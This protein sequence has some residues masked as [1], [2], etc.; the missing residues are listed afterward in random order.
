MI[1]S[2]HALEGKRRVVFKQVK[3]S[4]EEKEF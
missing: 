4:N 1:T 3:E 2:I